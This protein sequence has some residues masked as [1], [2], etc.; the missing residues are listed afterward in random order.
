MRHIGPKLPLRRSPEHGLYHDYVSYMDEIKQNLKNV[1]L[2]NPGERIGDNNFGVGLRHMLLED[3][4]DLT[5]ERIKNR[6]YEQVREYVN[7]VE[8]GEVEIYRPSDDKI[9]FLGGGDYEVRVRL[10]YNVPELVEE[11]VLELFF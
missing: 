9:D 5:A 10:H 2:T 3:N 7:M 8:M 11:D 1:I 4:N 6:V